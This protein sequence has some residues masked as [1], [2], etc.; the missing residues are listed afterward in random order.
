MSTKEGFH[1][2]LLIV[3]TVSFLDNVAMKQTY[4]LWVSL[5]TSPEIH[6][7][8]TSTTLCDLR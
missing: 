8:L 5:I 1:I 7:A 3:T 6:I 2:I 4:V